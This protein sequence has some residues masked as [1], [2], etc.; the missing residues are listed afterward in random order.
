MLRLVPQA[1]IEIAG[2]A[3]APLRRSSEWMFL[4]LPCQN[5]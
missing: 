2:I 1:Q 5:Q 3:E 4:V